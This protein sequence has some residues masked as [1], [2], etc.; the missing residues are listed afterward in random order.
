ML[1]AFLRQPPP[2]ASIGR[3][4]IS[5]EIVVGANMAAGLSSTPGE[6]EVEAA[7]SDSQGSEPVTTEST[8]RQE[9]TEETKPP[10]DAKPAI[11]PEPSPKTAMDEPRVE[12]A[13]AEEREPERASDNISEE[14]VE[15]PVAE[16]SDTPPEPKAAE[17]TPPEEAKP[18]P[19]AASPLRVEETS[20]PKQ[21]E[22]QAAPVAG[23]A[24]AGE[25]EVVLE[26]MLMPEARPEQAPEEKKEASLAKLEPAATPERKTEPR[27]ETAA[28]K[29]EPRRATA[30]QSVASTAA[31]GVGRGRSDRDTNYRGLV[32]AHLARYKRFPREAQSRG[33]EGSVVVSFLLGGSGEVRSVSLVR[34]THVASLDEEAVA[35]VR[36]ASPFPAPPDGRP[37]SFTVP[38]SF[39]I[40]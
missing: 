26:K 5:V 25:M 3:E 7:A 2:L 33:A 23:R 39:E 32:A 19:Q 1:A 17:V 11:E 18:E 30:R 40:R 12:T 6:N 8:A 22:L 31:S 28:R 9:V 14:S 34:G 35:M 13:V 16:K 37:V 29:K 20:M 38:V 4:V 10:E 24:A 21:A 27:R 15:T 36:R